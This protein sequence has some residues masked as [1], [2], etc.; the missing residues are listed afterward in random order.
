MIKKFLMAL[1]AYITLLTITTALNPALGFEVAT[2]TG[3]IIAQP[4]TLALKAGLAL[5]GLI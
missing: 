1:I 5:R 2:Y 3:I 4:I